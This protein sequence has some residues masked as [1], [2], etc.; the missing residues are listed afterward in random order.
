MKYL[1][2]LHITSEK[3]YCKKYETL[4]EANK[5]FNRCVSKYKNLQAYYD[6]VQV[7]DYISVDEIEVVNAKYTNF[8]RYDV[9]YCD[10]SK[11]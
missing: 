8:I 1:L 4:Q 6:G 7:V 5:V 10:G 11:L 2:T 3:S 9:L